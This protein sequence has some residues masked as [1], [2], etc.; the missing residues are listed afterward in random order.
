MSSSQFS[1][2]SPLLELLRGGAVEAVEVDGSEGGGK[3][4]DS[5]FEK[6]GGEAEEGGGEMVGLLWAFSGGFCAGGGSGIETS[7][8]KAGGAE[9]ERTL[10]EPPF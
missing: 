3:G 10:R 9:V 1:Q 2:F 5:S 6:T 4:T 7:L 8:E